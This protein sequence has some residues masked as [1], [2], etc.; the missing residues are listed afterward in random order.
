MRRFLPLLLSITLS[1][2]TPFITKKLPIVSSG[3]LP[4][5]PA[6]ARGAGITG[7]VVIEVETDGVRVIKAT[8]KSGPPMLA[9]FVKEN[10]ESWGFYP[11]I[12]V[13][14]ESR[15]KFVLTPSNCKTFDPFSP[16]TTKLRLP[17][18]AE[19]TMQRPIDCDP[20]LPPSGKEL[21]K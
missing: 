4:V 21:R 7:T 1:G 10:V 13:R 15:F 5:Y 19:L 16:G 9:K 17:Y 18:Y 14:F 8:I 20:V 2:Q 3:F 12:P 11:H 6:S